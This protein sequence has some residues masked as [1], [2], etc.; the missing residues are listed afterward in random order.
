MLKEIIGRHLF[1]PSLC[2]KHLSNQLLFILVISLLL[3]VASVS[4]ESIFDDF[5]S[6]G[7][8]SIKNVA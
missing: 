3:T 6:K 5:L 4:Q 8:V 7:I 2:K 1:L